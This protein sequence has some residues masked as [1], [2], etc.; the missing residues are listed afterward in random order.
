LGG[1]IGYF[2]LLEGGGGGRRMRVDVRVYI[3]RFGFL[4]RYGRKE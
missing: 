3:Y 1:V 2:Y 4:G